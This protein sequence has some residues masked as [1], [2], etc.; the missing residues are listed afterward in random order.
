[1]TYNL[2]PIKIQQAAHPFR[3]LAREVEVLDGVV[4]LVRVALVQA[5]AVVEPRLRRQRGGVRGM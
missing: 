4:E 2:V 1:M 3:I 5:L